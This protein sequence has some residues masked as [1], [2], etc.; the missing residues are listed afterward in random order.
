MH[1]Q[2]FPPLESGAASLP[3]APVDTS[4]PLCNVQPQ[5]HS[6]DSPSVVITAEDPCHTQ[7]NTCGTDD[8]EEALRQLDT[9]R[10]PLEDKVQNWLDTNLSSH[11]PEALKEE[12][13]TAIP[14][15]H[16]QQSNARIVPKGPLTA[17]GLAEGTVE[18]TSEQ[19]PMPLQNLRTVYL[20]AKK[21]LTAPASESVTTASAIA[22]EQPTIF[23]SHSNKRIA[24]QSSDRSVQQVMLR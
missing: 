22:S 11:L 2:P 4:T 1:V 12:A 20:A 3:H 19:N 8:P 13:C 7:I 24:G 14:P 21:K 18:H 10:V 23:P 16:H 9:Q 15:V 5:Q 6:P 17:V